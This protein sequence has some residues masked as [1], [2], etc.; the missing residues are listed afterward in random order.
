MSGRQPPVIA[1]FGSTGTVG[2]R[3]CRALASSDNHPYHVRALTRHPRSPAA[4]QVESLHHL[5]DNLHLFPY[6]DATDDTA[7]TAALDSVK[8]VFFLSPPQQA[9]ADVITRWLTAGK[10]QLTFC[11]YLSCDVAGSGE[12][13]AAAEQRVR[14]S[15][16]PFALLRPTVLMDSVVTAG[17]ADVFGI[18]KRV[19]TGMTGDAA[20]AAVDARDIADVACKMLTAPQAD[21]GRYTGQ[22]YRLTG[23]QAVSSPALCL[24]LSQHFLQSIA[25]RDMSEGQ[26]RHWLTEKRKLT[27]DR[28]D[29]IVA[30][31]RSLQSGDA[32]RPSAAVQEVLGVPA[33][34][35]PAFL[36]EYGGQ[37]LNVIG[38]MD[39]GED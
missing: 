24:L 12:H 2:S 3:V 10:A 39:D 15:G 34:G 37:F 26:Y 31:Q 16:V 29:A 7:L 13:H 19:M 36:T 14:D 23:S 18:R 11:V 35:W 1:V 5:H 32:S 33:R 25:Y 8:R 21:V 20:I 17:T 6:P 4:Q 9:D 38:E 28:A 27:A 22:T 30:Q